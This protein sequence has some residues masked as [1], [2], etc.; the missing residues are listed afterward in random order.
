MLSAGVV[1]DINNPSDATEELLARHYELCRKKLLRQHPW[2]F[3]TKRAVLAA[4]SNT[5]AFGYSYQFSLPADFIRLLSVC[6]TDELIV[7]SNMYQMEGNKILIFDTYSDAG[8]LNIKYIYDMKTVSGFDPLFISLLSYELAL[9]IAYKVT[10]SNTNV[11][12]I[13]ELRKE[14]SAL[15][16]AIDG[17]E[18][19]PTRIESS[20][21]LRARRSGSYGR[22]STRYSF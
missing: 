18:R 11:Q 6:G 8:A 12:R 5:P 20:R 21:A 7:P 15:A 1:T 17:Q 22:D 9:A 16:R 14:L 19:P 10:D 2:N 13:S 3:A 4:D